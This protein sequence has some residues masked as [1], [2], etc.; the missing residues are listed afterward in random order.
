FDL[1]DKDFYWIFGVE[2]EDRLAPFKT[3]TP[4]SLKKISFQ[5]GSDNS[6][7][8]KITLPFILTLLLYF[9][10]LNYNLKAFAL[11]IR[12]TLFFQ[13]MGDIIYP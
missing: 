13:P 7:H 9:F 2:G 6:F 5:A 3:E 12:L 4:K 11:Q 1:K 8:P 10:N